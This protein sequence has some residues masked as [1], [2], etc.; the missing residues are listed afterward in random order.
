LVRILII[1][2]EENI[3]YSITKTLAR[4][5]HEVRDVA[6]LP[7]ARRLLR[8][9]DFDVV[10][11]DVLL[12]GDDGIDLV[13]E[14]RSDAFEG[15]I[16][17]ITAHGSVEHAVTAMRLGADDY[18]QKPLSMQELSLAIDRC[19]EHR[20]LARRVALYDRIER[21]RDLSRSIVGRSAAWRN[22]LTVASRLAAI[23]I[24]PVEEPGGAD[25]AV[26][27]PELPPEAR[28]SLPCILLVGETGVGKG[29]LARYIHA[30]GAAVP[31]DGA[32]PPFVHVNCSTLPATLVEAE[33]FGHEKGAFTDAREA[34]PGLFEM[35]D[36][37]T[38]FLDEVSEMSP[39]LQAKLLLV[40]ERGVYRRVGGTRDRSVRVRVVAASN[41][42]LEQRV[43]KGLFRRDL[44]YRLNAFI[45]RIPPLRDRPGDAVLL[46]EVTLRDSSRRYGGRPLEL[47][48]EAK[49]AIVAYD[50]PGNVREL[51]NAVQRA[52]MLCEGSAVGPGDLGIPQAEAASAPRPAGGEAPGGLVFDFEQGIHTVEE[53]ER[54]LLRQALERTRGNVSRAARLVGMQRSSFRLRID[55]YKLYEYV[56]EVAGR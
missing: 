32:A 16:V 42:D 51:V 34:R 24:A 3:R 6:S 2:D 48:E 41:Q 25:D 4:A 56:S 44:L 19:V 22:V 31:D 12:G 46:A 1:E 17:V 10:L 18:L 53:V 35:A 43:S 28:A 7:E 9:S 27:D 45:I 33:L 26:A 52:A 30:C 36:G 21:T 49:K 37:G 50:W 11:T 20:R 47:T 15:G 40:V 13:R 38:I 54:A 23:P 55:R 39:E 14:L 5:G 8:V 29:V